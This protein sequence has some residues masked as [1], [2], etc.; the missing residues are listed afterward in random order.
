MSKVC[1]TCG[2]CARNGKYD[3][4]CFYYKEPVRRDHDS[5][6]HYK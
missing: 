3:Y 1:A 4:Y 6:S 5:C 2:W